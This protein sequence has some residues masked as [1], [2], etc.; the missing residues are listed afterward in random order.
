M[1]DLVEFEFELVGLIGWLVS[2]I[3]FEFSW[4]SWIGWVDLVIS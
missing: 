4:F 2:W 1:L 3:E